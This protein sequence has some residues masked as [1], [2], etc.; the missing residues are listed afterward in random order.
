MC[1]QGIKAIT[2][3]ISKP[4]MTLKTFHIPVL[5]KSIECMDTIC[6]V[7]FLYYEPMMW[8][9]CLKPSFF[10]GNKPSLYPG[11]IVEIVIKTHLPRGRYFF[12]N[13]DNVAFAWMFCMKNMTCLKMG[14]DVLTFL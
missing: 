3:N 10:C 13:H 6:V 2:E 12:N 4:K 11:N 1:G 9:L 7:L 14:N 8:I 5:F